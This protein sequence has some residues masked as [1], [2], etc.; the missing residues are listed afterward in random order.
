MFKSEW[1]NKFIFGDRGG[2]VLWKIPLGEIDYEPIS[3]PAEGVAVATL[4]EN[5]MKV[6][7]LQ[8]LLVWKCKSLQSGTV[9]RLISGRRRLEALRM[10]GKTHVGAIVVDCEEEDLPLLALSDNL[11]RRE[12]EPFAVS[13]NVAQLID[14]GYSIPRLSRL[15]GVSGTVI[16]QFLAARSLTSA[17]QR[18][19]KMCD[20]SLQDVIA[21]FQIPEGL[22]DS[23]LQRAMSDETVSVAEL[24]REYRDN[25]MSSVLQ[26]LK[27]W[28]TDVRLFANTVERGV[29]TMQKGGMQCNIEQMESDSEV[30]FVIRF[31]KSTTPNVADLRESKEE[32]VSRETFSDDSYEQISLAIEEPAFDNIFKAIAADEQTDEKVSRI[33]NVSRETFLHKNASKKKRNQRENAEKLE[34]CIDEIGKR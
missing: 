16:E 18:S 24:A 9:Y 3:N 13:D 23:V 1:I 20:A 2:T 26:S 14:S 22:R 8:P 4:A 25:P 17:Q 5:I 6:G 7:L 32:N 34:F 30:S 33:Q 12:M 28:S 31:K 29:Q 21:F 11:M 27:I 10:L 15:L 19:L